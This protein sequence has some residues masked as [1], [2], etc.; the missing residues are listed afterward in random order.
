MRSLGRVTVL[1]HGEL[2]AQGEVPQ[3]ELAVAAAEDQEESKQVEQEALA[4]AWE[5]RA[6]GTAWRLPRRRS[7]TLQSTS[8]LTRARRRGR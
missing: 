6:A 3:G 7:T 1:V 5:E 4:H 8:S 2:V